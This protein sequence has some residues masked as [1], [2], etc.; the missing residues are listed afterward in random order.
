MPTKEM[1][2]RDY[3]QT[4]KLSFNDSNDTLGVDGFIVGKIGNTINKVNTSATVET[5][6]FYQD[7][8]TLLYQITITY[9][10]STKN[11]FISVVR[12]A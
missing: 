2:Q 10:D 3:Q 8:T 11:D 4:L 7:Y 1:S 9:V 5:Y 6:S 12:T